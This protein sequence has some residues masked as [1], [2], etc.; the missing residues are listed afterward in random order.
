MEDP[1]KKFF[2]YFDKSYNSKERFCSYWHQI[3]EIVNLN[4]KSVLEIG[5]GNRFVSD[6]LKKIG[7]DITALDIEKNLKPNVVGNVVSIP[8]KSNVFD[9]VACYEIL[10][11][12][13]YT[14]FKLA[15]LEIFRVSKKFAILSLPDINRVYPLIIKIPKIKEI[16]KLIPLPRI[17]KPSYNFSPDHYWEI[18]TKNFH[19]KKITKDIQEAGFIIK[20]TYRVFE[21]PYHRF[22]ILKK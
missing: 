2:P 9:V 11:H 18:G 16:K 19:L 22:F 17:K 14:D 4:P 3:H 21:Y 8:F 6:Y 7:I 10:E 13:P 5:I 12:L 15:L 1:T 20:R